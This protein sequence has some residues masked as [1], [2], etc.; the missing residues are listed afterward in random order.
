M[1]TRPAYLIAYGFLLLMLG[2]FLAFGMVVR[3]IEPGFSLEF[4]LLRRVSVRSCHGNLRRCGLS[5]SE[6]LDAPSGRSAR[7][8]R[9]GAPGLPWDFRTLTSLAW[10]R[11]WIEERARLP[12]PLLVPARAGDLGKRAGPWDPFFSRGPFVPGNGIT[13][14][15]RVLGTPCEG[16]RTVRASWQGAN[17]YPPN[18][19]N[20][21]SALCL[22]SR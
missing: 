12:R 22:K 5:T 7:P 1:S 18:F 6:A 3:L 11:A 15:L 9:R 20:D 14:Q 8:V 10:I 19:R 4:S 2:F 17:I 21:E 16:R 13:L